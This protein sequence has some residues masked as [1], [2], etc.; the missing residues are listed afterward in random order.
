M[1][2]RPVAEARF[3]EQRRAQSGRV[4]DG[5][6]LRPANYL[7]S[8]TAW[9][10]A[11]DRLEVVAVEPFIAIVEGDLVSRIDVVVDLRVDLPAV[12]VRAG[13]GG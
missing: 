8:E 10:G 2:I 3:I 7:R 4:V 1:L 12:R 9:P 6:H 11:R 5:Q 13:S